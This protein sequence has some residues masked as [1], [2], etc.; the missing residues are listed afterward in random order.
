MTALFSQVLTL[1]AAGAL[2]ILLVLAAR[3]LL[4]RGPRLFPFLLW[5]VAF[6]RLLLPLSLKVSLPVP[7]DFD[8]AGL[9]AQWAE[10]M[11]PV[12]PSAPAHTAAA[13]GGPGVLAVL[14]WVWA[15]GAA[16]VALMGLI[17]Y[18]RLRRALRPAVRLEGNVWTVDQ[19]GAPFVVGLLRPRIYLPSELEDSERAYILAHERCHI[20]RLDHITKLLAF[21]ALAVHWFNPLVWVAFRLF[22]QDMESSCDEAVLRKL[23]EHIRSDYSQSL[24]DLTAGRRAPTWTPLAFGEGNPGRRIRNILRWKRPSAGAVTLAALFTLVIALSAMTEAS[25]ADLLP[26]APTGSAEAAAQWAE[27]RT[28]EN[29][30]AVITRSYDP[31]AHAPLTEGQSAALAGYLNRLHSAPSGQAPDMT[32]LCTISAEGGHTV[33]LGYHGGTICVTVDGWAVEDEALA[34]FLYHVCISNGTISYPSRHLPE[35]AVLYST[36]HNVMVYEYNCSVCGQREMAST[37]D[38]IACGCCSP[39]DDHHHF[40][41]LIQ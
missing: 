41:R 28:A 27:T 5:I 10:E 30:S 40:N 8:A 35:G 2:V 24:L 17:S 33:C 37:S 32:T 36:S 7:T 31:G 22:T 15:A 6:L 25:G 19:M 18:L 12:S 16:V 4:R 13:P 26:G 21:C 23:G 29:L 38:A 1:S 39:N 11:A 20:R 9:V 3:M 14:G 34:A